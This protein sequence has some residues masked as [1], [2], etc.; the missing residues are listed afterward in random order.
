MSFLYDDRSEFSG[1]TYLEDD[2]VEKS[3]FI[4]FFFVFRRKYLYCLFLA[5]ANPL[6]RAHML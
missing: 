3:L 6:N 1:S 5:A 2:Q 4:V